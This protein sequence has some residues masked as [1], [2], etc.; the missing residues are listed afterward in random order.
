MLIWFIERGPPKAKQDFIYTKDL[1]QNEV[2]QM[3]C[4]AMRCDTVPKK[5]SKR[6][7]VKTK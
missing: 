6:N 4:D 2:M 5:M 1:K 3:R 7:K